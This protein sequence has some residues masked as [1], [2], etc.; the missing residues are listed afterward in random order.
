MKGSW[1]PIIWASAVAGRLV[2]APSTVTGT[3]SP[4]KATGAVLKIRTKT[5]ASNGGK[6]TRISS[7]LVIATGVPNPATPSSSAPKQKPITTSTMRRSFGKCLSTQT[8]K[9]SNRPDLTATL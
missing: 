6:P 4:P 3:P 8:R 1:R 7:E 9:A 5:I 2:T